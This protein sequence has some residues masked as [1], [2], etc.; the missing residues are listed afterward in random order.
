[1]D[2]MGSTPWTL[3]DWAYALYGLAMFVFLLVMVVATVWR[4]EVL[5]E[6]D[7]PPS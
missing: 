3:L 1:M 6:D 2:A 5:G 4:E 7:Q